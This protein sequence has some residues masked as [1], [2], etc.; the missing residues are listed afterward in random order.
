MGGG[1]TSSSSGEED[2]D[3]EW[4]A[5]IDS[6]TATTAFSSSAAANGHPS[7]S[8]VAQPSCEDGSDALKPR[9]LNHYQIKVHKLLEDFLEKTIEIV[10]DTTDVIPE[11]PNSCS[12]G[13]IRLFKHAPPGIA[14]DNT[15]ELYKNRKKPRILP[16]TELEEGS[17]EFKR[18]IR[19]VSVAG[20]DIVAAAKDATQKSKARLEARDAATRSYL[21][22]EE[23]R[24]A[25]LKKIRGEKWLPSLAPI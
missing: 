7:S 5:A 21:Q 10:S 25:E 12:E 19:S 3:A 22:R 4:R 2:G 8:S 18:R 11:D 15:D 9:K 16:G 17:K 6:L 23:E 1:Q 14:V 24:V 20:M 13:G